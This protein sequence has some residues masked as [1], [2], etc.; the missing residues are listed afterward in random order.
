M[1]WQ[2]LGAMGT[3]AALAMPLAA[4]GTAAGDAAF[5]QQHFTL[6]DS[7]Y[8]DVLAHGSPDD[9]KRAALA[10][11][12]MDWHIQR[13]TTRAMRD[14]QAFAGT[15]P[16]LVMASRA[17]L[18]SGNVT[19]AMAA[20]R[21]AI[22][23]A[24]DD[25]GRRDAAVAL[26]DVA[27]F[28]PEHSCLD[29]ATPISPRNDAAI[30]DAR[31]HLHR[32]VVVEPGQLEPAG[33][34]IRL[35]ALTGDW[36]SLAVGVRSYY[37]VG[38]RVPGGPLVLAES[39]LRA[40]DSEGVS[41][42][43][44]HA[45]AALVDAKQFEAAALIVTCGSLA[46]Q[47][48]DAHTREIIAYARFLRD[49]ERTTERYYGEVARAHGDT[50]R[51][52]A[53]FFAAGR[54]LWPLLDWQGPVPE[55]TPDTLVGELDLRFGLVVN[56]GTTAGTFDLHAGH[57]ISD[58]ARVVSQ[59]GHTATVRFAVLD[60]MISDGYQSWAWDGIAQHGGWASSDLIIQVREAY[61][62]GPL[63][64]WHAS[65]DSAAIRRN[66]GI[67]ARDSAAD[68]AH[69]DETAVGDFS[70]LQERLIRDARLFLLDS[71]RA[72]GLTGAALQ[73][74]FEHRYGDDVDESSI[75]AH[76]GRHAI[77]RG[78]HL[79]DSTAANLE[80][81]AKLSEVAFAPSPRLALSG[82]VVASSSDDTP[83]G[84]ANARLM[85]GLLDWMAHHAPT[86]R[87]ASLALA[88]PLLTDEQLREAVR[89]LDPLA[90][91]DASRTHV[92]WK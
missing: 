21:G 3:A 85:R 15:V 66:A 25:Q 92:Y 18:A 23:A 81:R 4:Q 5:M 22:A 38:H 47:P 41:E 19:G 34:L 46:G 82:I 16:A 12:G 9:R 44:R 20:A 57:R 29:S 91:G 63:R 78:L 35:A 49:A 13:D 56:L 24:H 87:D 53:S 45:F 48:H 33:R 88:I 27:L 37:V 69:T 83:H 77:D 1:I 30:R 58:E 6:A 67:I 17:R 14:L 51:W 42:M 7:A 61:A 65:T 62:N 36:P 54:R 59:Y 32:I 50:A 90:A 76:E 26:A 2:Y 86:P 28:T 8:R 40:M 70:S 84:I 60:G 10:L 64:A 52:Q 39:A 79:T 43:G 31:S 74:R 80:Y 72:S 68:I 55:F 11:A 89:S 75:F 71:L 73:S